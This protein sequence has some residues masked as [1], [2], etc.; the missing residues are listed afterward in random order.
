MLSRVRFFFSM[1]GLC[2]V[3][4]GCPVKAD[5]PVAETDTTA[6]ASDCPL[7][8]AAVKDVI[9]AATVTV[10]T[11]DS[12]G[13]NDTSVSTGT[14]DTSGAWSAAPK[15]C[16]TDGVYRVEV[17]DGTYTSEA[18]KEAVTNTVAYT[19]LVDTGSVDITGSAESLSITPVSTFID[20]R[21]ANILASSKA[22]M[23]K[24]RYAGVSTLAD[25]IAAATTEVKN[26][27]GLTANP[28]TI[29]VNISDAAA[30]A[31]NPEGTKMGLI[32]GA[33]TEQ[34]KTFADPGNFITALISDFADG[35]FD[36]TDATGAAITVSDPTAGDTTLSADA[37]TTGF[38]SAL[39]DYL[40]GTDNAF[41]DSGI[42]LA[43]ISDIISDINTAIAASDT[44]IPT[45]TSKSPAADATDVA[46]DTNVTATFSEAMLATTLTGTSFTLKQGSTAI[47]GAVTN[48]DVSGATTS[49]FNPTGTL[50]DET[51]YTA[52]L[53]TTI[54]DAAGNALAAT[55]WDFTTGSLYTLLGGDMQGVELVLSGAVTTIAGSSAGFLNHISGT[56]AQFMYPYGITN[57]GT[58]LYVADTGNHTIRQIVIATGAVTTLAGS[59]DQYITGTTD[60][61]GTLA[62]FN[63]PHGVTTDG[64][65]VW[66]ADRTNHT[67][68]KIVISTGAVTTIAGIAGS[69][70]FLDHATG[71]SATFNLPT[72]ITTDGTNLYVTDSGTHLVRKIVISSGAV[73]TIAGTGTTGTADGDGTA[74]AFNNP[75]GIAT[76]G[77]YLYV[78][79]NTNATIRKITIA[80]PYTVSTLVGPSAGLVGPFGIATD[81]TNLYIGDDNANKVWETVKLSGALTL[82]AGSGT[83]TFADGTGVSASFYAPR[84]VTT[85]GTYVYVVD[86]WNSRIRRIE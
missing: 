57:D 48:A 43:D 65:Y 12:T 46:V 51:T 13:T 6:T 39:T 55:T 86:G 30:V 66:V 80:S 1:I 61:T 2:I 62:R 56:S 85:N 76:D 29:V 27:F 83:A 59:Q 70:G 53:A 38:T 19:A 81:G 63:G 32:L 34:A 15:P 60:A 73:S 24:G 16:A 75:Y 37:G 41:S 52:A 77:T 40:A 22:G 42:V 23:G 11:V 82:V 72:G 58:N 71:T 21:A 17:T 8:G 44:A 28:L 25:A 18:T 49:T 4:A 68:R 64:T 33:M 69:P 31:T 26:L 36:G 79:D 45:V 5:D 67:I 3:L 78:V 74:A 10:Y 9:N 50:A 47:S 7:G 14:T 35:V 84:G 54:T 20:E